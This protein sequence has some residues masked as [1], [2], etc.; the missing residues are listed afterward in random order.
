MYCSEISPLTKLTNRVYF[1]ERDLV[2]FL[3]RCCH[4]NL[5][6][7]RDC[8]STL[9]HFCSPSVSSAKF[10]TCFALTVLPAIICSRWNCILLA[11]E[12]EKFTFFF[13]L[14]WTFLQ[15]VVEWISRPINLAVLFM[16]YAS[17]EMKSYPLNE[18]ST[19]HT[20]R[21][22]LHSF[23]KSP[24]TQVQFWNCSF[25]S[26]VNIEYTKKFHL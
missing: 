8:S 25:H 2:S 3:C 14:L 4:T 21:L 18:M 16:E 15:C 13:K 1:L 24:R 12:L 6:L 17:L 10:H 7:W 20:Q 5:K 26:F 11:G 23:R 19:C 9:G 22:G